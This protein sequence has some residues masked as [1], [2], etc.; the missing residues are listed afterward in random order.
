MHVFSYYDLYAQG[1]VTCMRR[2]VLLVCAG[3][4]YLYAQGGVT[5][6]P[7]AER[8]TAFPSRYTSPSVSRLGWRAPSVLAYLET[9]IFSPQD[10]VL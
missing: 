1:G 4:C 10:R 3:R 7:F 6:S 9:P 2:A 5:Y 8:L